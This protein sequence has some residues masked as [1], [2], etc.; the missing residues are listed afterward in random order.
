MK[1]DMDL[2]RTILL[3]VEE[4]RDGFQGK[5]CTPEMPGQSLENIVEHLE[6]VIDAGLLVAEVQRSMGPYRPTIHIERL[7]WEGHEFLDAARQDS[8]WNQAKEKM[9]ESTGGLSLSLLKE[10]LVQQGKQALGLDSPD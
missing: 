7:T 3:A 5:G 8:L 6:I 9:L 4:G 1:R 2:V 10:L